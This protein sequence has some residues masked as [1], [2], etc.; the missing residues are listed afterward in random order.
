MSLRAFLP[1]DLPDLVRAFADPEIRR[2]NPGPAEE[3][4]PMAV[5]DWMTRRND[6]SDG[7]HASW[8]VA[9][10]AGALVGSVSLHKIDRAQGD[11]EV[12]YWIAP[13]ARGRGRATSALS[14]AARYGFGELGLHRLF[15]FHAVEN[16]GSCRV[17]EA[18]GFPREGVLRQSYRYGDGPYH[19]EHLHGRLS[20]DPPVQAGPGR[21]SR[22]PE[23]APG[24]R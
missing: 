23:H 19:D 2:W 11:A 16:V 4:Q 24:P 15:L 1:G 10:A 22:S 7:S 13:G 17:A 9:D 20:S 14:S 21:Y 5:A 6:W 18:A 3:D 12:G 8:A